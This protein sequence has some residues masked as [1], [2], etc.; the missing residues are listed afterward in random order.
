MSNSMFR[1]SALAHLSSPDHLDDTIEVTNARAWLALAA[2]GVLMTSAV[3]WGVVARIPTIVRAEG[4]LVHASGVQTVEAP[5]AGR[6]QA[7]LVKAGERIEP[8]QAV[9]RIGRADGQ[10][11]IVTAS[12]A[13]QVLDLR[14]AAGNEVNR[15]AVLLSYEHL[16]EPLE[17]RLYLAPDRARQVE[18]G[19]IVQLALAPARPDD[20]G[21]LLGEVAA[22]GSFPATVAGVQ[23]VLGSED[24]ARALVASGPPV[25][26]RV[27]LWPG[28]VDG[29]YRWRGAEQSPGRLAVLQGG[30]PLTAEIIAAEQPPIA[31]V[32]GQAQR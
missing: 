18:P 2:I 31:L 3:V 5:T 1:R 26:V 17:A 12:T 20:A 32:L 29:Q 15:G 10:I 25:E 28:A 9:V 24:L 23:R 21:V 13:G 8:D 19:M 16:D 7:M 6:V 4:Y 27:T 14:A 30:I 22:V 11:D